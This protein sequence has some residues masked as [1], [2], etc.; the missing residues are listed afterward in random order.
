MKE[1]RAQICLLVISF[2]VFMV[3]GCG[4]PAETEK[5]VEEATESEVAEDEETKEDDVE[6]DET[7]GLP[8]E[9]TNSIGMKFRLI[10]SGEF[11]MGAVSGDGKAEDSESP[12]HRVEITKPFYIGIY[13]VTQ[14]QYR[15]VMGDNPSRFKSS[16]RPVEQVSWNNAKEFCRKL[17]GKEG[18]T[19]RLPT[20]AEWEYACRARTTTKYYW[21]DSDSESTVKRYVWYAKNA[22]KPFWTEP[23][24]SEDG[25]QEVG[26]KLPNAWGLYD[27]SG[28]VLE[29]CEDR[30][31]SYSSS[32][33]RDPKGPSSG[34][35]RVARGGGWGVLARHVRSSVRSRLEPVARFYGLGF[36][37][38]REV[39]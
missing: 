12:R 24:A 9:I 39:E 2:L 20:E 14:A 27:M 10:P 26:R 29:W 17:S 8:V 11:M 5:D 19:Y 32:S 31:G 25:P 16:R 18:V 37:I 38:V 30:Y 28:N 13:E 3:Y 21:G 33:Q 4:P 7:T 15:A 34:E 22:A 36:R 6:I 23:H 35:A 1:F